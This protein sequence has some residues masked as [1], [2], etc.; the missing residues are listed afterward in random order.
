MGSESLCSPYW[1]SVTEPAIASTGGADIGTRTT[2]S[3]I[4]KQTEYAPLSNATCT[5][6]L[7]Q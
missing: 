1:S 7:R 4:D 6:L 2:M 3:V 5:I